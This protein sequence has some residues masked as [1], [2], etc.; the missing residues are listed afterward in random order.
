[1]AP[2]RLK[3]GENG[4][5]SIPAAFRRELGVRPGDELI[6]RVEDGELRITSPKL[7]L[8]RAR[9]IIGRYL[10]EGENLADSLIADR[11]AEAARE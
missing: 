7:A 5:I 4:R 2:R 3:I 6:A 11:R 1:M 10:K 9:R 8:E